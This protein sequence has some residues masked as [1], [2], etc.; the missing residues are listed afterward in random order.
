MP[1]NGSGTF[2]RVYDW[3]DDEAA[4]T[5]IESSRMDAEMDGMASGL[6]NCMTRDGQSPATADIPFGSNKATGLAD[7]TNAQDAA[8]KAWT[9]A[10][11]IK[12]D[13]S[14]AFSGDQSMD[15]NALTD[16]PAPS[17]ANDAVRKAYVDGIFATVDISSS[18]VV[19]GA[20][21]G[22]ATIGTKRKAIRIDNTFAN[23]TTVIVD[24]LNVTNSGG[25][26]N[27]EFR[28]LGKVFN[29]YQ[30]IGAATVNGAAYTVVPS[31]INNQKVILKD[32]SGNA[33]QMTSLSS[34][35]ISFTITYQHT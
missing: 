31:D 21:G 26:G 1:F 33:L 30:A 29:G 17:A 6:S 8:T 28:A 19:E 22:S 3:T 7:P 16:L 11:F 25:S 9:E 32:T 5:D 15:G 12:E 14:T 18:I 20:G 13:G 4:G 23:C 24:L 10:T 2:T 27:A 34:T 35:G